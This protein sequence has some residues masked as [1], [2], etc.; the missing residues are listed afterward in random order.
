MTKEE[1]KAYMVVYRNV[2]HDR[3][4]AQHREY[5]ATHQV[6]QK[7]I[8]DAERKRRAA[9]HM[10]HRAE[11]NEKTRLRRLANPEQHR[12]TDRLWK[13]SHPEEVC[14]QY[15]RHAAKRRALGF[16]PLNQQFEGCEGHHLNQKDVIYIP[17]EMHRTISHDVWTG[18]GMEEINALACAWF[19]EDWT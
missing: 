15:K 17:K 3:I 7:V 1:K 9:K 6:K 11:D 10:E 14:L 16:I 12:E 2:N 18:R 8:D 19:T 13:V 5:N 4:L